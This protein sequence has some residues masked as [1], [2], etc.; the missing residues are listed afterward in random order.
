MRT[1]SLLG[2][3]PVRGRGV[4]DLGARDGHLSKLLVDRFERVVALDLE[5]PII[6][7][8][9]VECVQGDGVCL[10]FPD[11]AFDAVVCAEVLEHVPPDALPRMAREI[12]RVAAAC[13]VIGV[14]YKQDLR[15]GETTCQSCGRTNPPWGH[16]NAFVEAD[17]SALFRGLRS[18]RTEFVGTT[19]AKTNGLSARLMRFASNPYGTYAQEEACI[20]CS[21]R[22]LP[23]THR[24]QVQRVATQVAHWT[25]RAQS[26]VT[27][28]QPN[29]IH[30]LFE[31]P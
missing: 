8:A 11:D 19:T 13:V 21:A 25:T 17:L 23:P 27:R 15:F 16:V 4:L 14:P 3:L 18:S 29:W 12:A 9:R 1:Q 7:D 26:V 22:L 30:V 20:H 6:D 31:K 10:E 28:R 24:T 2:L 5:K